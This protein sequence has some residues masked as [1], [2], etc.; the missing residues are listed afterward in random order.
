[1]VLLNVTLPK[2]CV[3]IWSSAV[4]ALAMASFMEA[5]TACGVC[6]HSGIV[7]TAF[8][9]AAAL[10]KSSTDFSSTAERFKFKAA[11]MTGRQRNV[12][13]I[14]CEARDLEKRNRPKIYTDFQR[15][16]KEV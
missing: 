9:F 13:F 15:W 8:V 12:D 5:S 3:P 14:E 6:S 10:R 2:S 7:K 11:R 4:F 16:A 1:M